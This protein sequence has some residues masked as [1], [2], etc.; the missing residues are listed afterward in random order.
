MDDW[1]ELN[2]DDFDPISEEV[3]KEIEE[4]YKKLLE[5][6]EGGDS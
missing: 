4:D 6:I 5:R 2:P 1:E 3:M